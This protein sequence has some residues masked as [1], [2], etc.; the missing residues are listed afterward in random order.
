M[1]DIATLLMLE[2]TRDFDGDVLQMILRS[3]HPELRRRAAMS[4]ARINDPRGRAMLRAAYPD[5]DTA[6][7]ASLI[8]GAG[9]MKDSA[10][11]KWLDTLLKQPTTPVTVAFEAAR[12]LGKIRTPEAHSALATYL[13][14]V[15]E[16]R[17][18]RSVIGEALLS[19]SRFSTRGD[20]GPIIRHTRSPDVEVRWR[21]TAS[22][23]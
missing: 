4:I 9:Q 8:F 2:D 7:S 17:F 19:I 18:T 12:S 23:K 13:A 14:G 21:A 22:S 1:A 10:A 5:A 3:P 6:V 15:K 16:T 11:A 20:L